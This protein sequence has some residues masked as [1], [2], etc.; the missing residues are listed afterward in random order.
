[1][2]VSIIRNS[3]YVTIIHH[4]LADKKKNVCHCFLKIRYAVFS[5]E[6]PVWGPVSVIRLTG[7]YNRNTAS[8]LSANTWN[9]NLMHNWEKVGED[10]KNC[11]CYIL[12][13]WPIYSVNLQLRATETEV[14]LFRQL[15]HYL[16][17]REVSC[18]LSP[19]ISFS[20]LFNVHYCNSGYSYGKS[21]VS[22][23]LGWE[24]SNCRGRKMRMRKLSY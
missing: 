23:V 20:K 24:L 3:V 11:T 13:K 4:S 15:W 14:A 8:I 19:F 12:D 21:F 10:Y 7:A 22:W 16:L 6:V 5:G 17:S 2:T 9:S 18:S 1:M